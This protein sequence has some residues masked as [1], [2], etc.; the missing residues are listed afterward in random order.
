MKNK[1]IAS[2]LI[3]IS[4]ITVLVLV[5]GIILLIPYALWFVVGSL[6]GKLAAMCF[7]MIVIVVFI[8]FII[9]E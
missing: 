2:I 5:L 3:V 1:I 9:S 6:I 4:H 8:N 7:L